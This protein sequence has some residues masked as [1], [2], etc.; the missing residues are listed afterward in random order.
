MVIEVEVQA[1]GI[2]NIYNKMIAENFSN[3]GKDMSIQI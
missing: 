3:L 2:E 1:K